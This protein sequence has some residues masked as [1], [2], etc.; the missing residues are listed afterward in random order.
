MDREQRIQATGKQLIEHASREAESAAK[1]ERWLSGFIQRIMENEMF[2]VQALRLVDVLPALND[3]VDLVDHLQA[4][5]SDEEFPLP[6]AVKFGLKHVRSKPTDKVTALAVRKAV[7]HIAHWFMGGVA[8]RDALS[9]AENYRQDNIAVT[10]DRVGEVTVSEAEAEAYLKDYIDIIND[11]RKVT[12]NWQTN[13]FLDRTNDRE[14]PRLYLSVKPS[15]LYSQINPR[16]PEASIKGLGERLRKLLRMAR[17]KHVFIC[18]D[19]EHYDFKD[20]ILH[21]FRELLSE[22][23][24][25]DWPH[26][27]IALQAY[28][29][30]TA[31]DIEELIAWTKERGTPISVR[32]VRGAY[33]D[34]ETIIARQHGWDIPVWTTKTETDQNYEHC[35]ELLLQQHETIHTA[36]G[37]HNIRS[38]AHAITVA[39]EV[40]LAPG[41]FEFQMLYGMAPALEK[42]VQQMG[43]YLRV[44][45]PFGELIPGMAYLTRRL[46]E[47]ASSQSFQRLT[48]QWTEPVETVLARPMLITPDK[49]AEDPETFRNDPWRRFT[50]ATE[51]QSFREAISAARQNIG[52]SHKLFITGRPVDSAEVITSVNPANVSEVIGEV[53][54]AT[55]EQADEAI[56]GAR[57]ALGSWSG[58]SFSDRADYLFRAAARLREQRE[59]FA[60]L[61]VLE[62]GKTWPE[63]DANV[64]EAID[65]LEFYGRCAKRLDADGGK[66][67][68]GETNTLHY[69][70]R[71]V[72]AVIPPWNFPLAILTGM[73]SAALVTGNPVILKPSSETPVIAAEFVRLMQALEL[74]PG[75]LQFL[76]GPGASLGDYLVQH[77]DIHCIAF[78]GSLEVGSHIVEQAAQLAAGQ[79]HFKHVIAEMGGKN[80]IIID[81]DADLDEAVTGT[82]TSAFGYQG[83]KCSAASR[84]IVVGEHYDLF[85]QRLV[86]ATRS[87]RIGMPEDP[88]VIIGPVISRSAQKRIQSVINKAAQEHNT[89]LKL[90]CAEYDQGCFVGPAIFSDVAPDSRLAQEEI[91]G[92]VLA[93]MRAGNFNEAIA[94]A[95][96]SRFALTG[97]LYSRN[98]DHIEQAER[99]LQVGNLYINR[100]I[101]AALVERQPF[102][103]FKLSG[104]GS[105][106][107]GYDYLLQFVIPRTVTENTLRKGYA[108]G[109]DDQATLST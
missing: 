16:A 87:L 83:Q 60:A 57:A 43:Q 65:F 5:F 79:H 106:A 99:E 92:P 7:Q 104:L 30:E 8:I 10:L 22:P 101:T 29:R 62:A 70:A 15:S 81:S 20:I 90:D 77:K 26:A 68:A 37:T 3:D 25:R 76:P 71:G 51:R 102:G 88:A 33:W 91:F 84:V 96:R 35:A 63:A 21:C 31:K 103:G 58:M 80:A 34:Q 66:N 19:M 108:P 17:E 40:G 97:G 32:L 94:I 45:I 73:T 69:Q 48:M 1:I 6:D 78:T 38:I 12:H 74:P 2:R 53:C 82:V 24:F 95:N 105:K 39:E 75:V 42:S 52:Q 4:Y 59:R 56:R 54:L 67:V 107:G 14:M 13:E 109:A 89:A 47:N 44:Y 72:C 9:V 61:E 49:P 36:I 100:R 41:A 64:T 50:A 55:T 98:P 11:G 85:L 46:L 93:V 23:E 86:A 28:L 27:G 18:L